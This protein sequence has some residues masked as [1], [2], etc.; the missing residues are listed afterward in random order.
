LIFIILLKSMTKQEIKY[1]KENS[2]LLSLLL[3]FIQFLNDETK[4]KND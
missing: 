1:I 4:D 2:K 3:S